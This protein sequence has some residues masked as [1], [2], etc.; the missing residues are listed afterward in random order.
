MARKQ[1]VDVVVVGSGAGGAPVALELARAG[2]RVVVLERGPWYAPRDFT[3][4][5]VAICRRNFF[6]PYP[7]PQQ[8]PHTIR[9]RGRQRAHLTTEGWVGVCVGGG[10]VHM[11]G[12]TYRFHPEDFELAS[13]SGGISG[14]TV[15][16]WPISYE[17]LAPFYDRAEALIG[18]SGQAGTN[19]F[20][21]PRRPYP[22]PP[23]P[24]NPTARLVEQAASSLGMHAFP[25]ARAIVSRPYGGRPP[26]NLC[27]FCG[28]YG[29]EN[30]SKS[31][32]LAS[33]LPAAEATG[34]VRIMPGCM[35]RRVR[36]DD[37]DRV[38]GVEYIDP[39]G[40]V[41]F[42]GAR[43]VVLAAT[44]IE[45]ARLLLLSK[46]GRFPDGLANRTG[47]VGRNLTFSTFGKGTAIFERG[48][49][50]E[51]LGK[52]VERLPFLLRSVQDDYWNEKNGLAL[53]KGG[54]YN[55]LLHHPNA[56]NAGVR[57]A[58]DSKW[59]LWGE[60]LKQRIHRYFH[61]ELWVE[62]EVFGEFLPHPGCYVDLDPRVV[63][64]F[65]LPVARI[66]MDHHPLADELNRF[67]TRRG[68]DILE[69][70]R[71]APLSVKPWTWAGTTYHLQHGTCRFGSN[72]EESVLDV[73]CQAHEVA[74]LYVTDGSFMPTSGAVPATPTILAN[75]LRVARHLAGR[76]RRGEIPR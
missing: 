70:M 16:D 64:G 24:P 59:A 42:L 47:L 2:A 22:L 34:R 12:F 53:P 9:K 44:A 52:A 38:Q 60:K 43:V 5:E 66:T 30:G 50:V 18:V 13:R 71:P 62:F 10:T 56:I 48:R 75:S 6:V 25:T 68:L 45:T 27:G 23:L 28:E 76:F 37:R 54:T 7:Y 69:A 31:S 4:D 63:D 26:C 3:H 40:K 72:P 39:D 46:A 29:C 58:M 14:S 74:N 49:L 19:P 61:E 41:R 33:L 20:E 73:N 1:K 8:H 32:V 67:C 11:S 17:Q 65:G 57:L 36:A 51:K 15:V 35:V 21:P 55:F